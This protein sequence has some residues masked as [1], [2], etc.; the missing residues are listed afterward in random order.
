M[1]NSFQS[2]HGGGAY[3]FVGDTFRAQLQIGSSLWPDRPIESHA[4]AF[5]HLAKV[6]AMDSSVDGVSVVPSTYRQD[7]F[8]IAL[9]L[10]KANSSAF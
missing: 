6:L 2:W 8:I 3:S 1:C 7:S 4:E 5:Y 9:D 10:E